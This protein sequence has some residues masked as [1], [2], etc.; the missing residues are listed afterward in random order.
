MLTQ[1]TWV[2][3]GFTTNQCDINF[4]TRASN[5]ANNVCDAG[6]FNLAGC[7]VVGH[8]QTA[9]ADHHD[10][11]HH[12]ADQVLANGV[13]LIDCLSNRHLGSNAIG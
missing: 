5:A 8:K 9:S 10:V 3:G 7:D 1:K 11:I 6:R 12:H 13:V 4:F 2:L